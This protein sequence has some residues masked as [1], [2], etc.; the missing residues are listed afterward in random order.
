MKIKW[1]GHSSFLI[2][3]TGGLRI[4]TD[5]YR[6]GG[7]LSY[8]DITEAADIVTVSHNHFDHNN[9][10]AV[11]GNP[12]VVKEAG[13]VTVKGIEF[14]G[15]PC[16]HDEMEGR[17]RGQNIIFCFEVDGIRVAHLGDLGHRLS[18]RQVSEITPV[19]VVLI[20]VGGHFTID[21]RV[22]TEVCRQLKPRVIIPMHYRNNR[23]RFAIAG[24]EGFLQGKSGIVRRD[25]SEVALKP[26]ELPLD[27]QIMV[28][29]PA[30]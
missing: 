23:C 6:R 22:A 15:V 5:P 7:E 29:P 4:I 28:L 19:D 21:A 27:P 2:T 18:E 3:S 17:V 26:E 30:L 1:L 9:I 14:R 11:R 12:E 10:A 16:F 20:P 8:G 25:T 13:T 24:V